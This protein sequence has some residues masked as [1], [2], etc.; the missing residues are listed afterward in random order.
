MRPQLPIW[1]LGAL[2]FVLASIR[3]A[4]HQSGA[5]DLACFDQPL[6]LLSQGLPPVSSVMGLHLLGDHA[7]WILW[8]LALLYRAWADPH[9][10]LLLQALT[11][12]L[13]AWTAQLLGRQAGCTDRQATTLALAY[14]A[15]PLVFNANLFDF[16]PD[17]FV[18]VLLMGALYAARAAK[19]GWCL[20]LCLAVAGCKE[21]MGLTVAGLGAYLVIFERRPWGAAV[22][23]LGLGSFAVDVAW[24]IP[25][26]SGRA[27]GAI[28]RYAYLGGSV[29]EIARNLVL[30][31]WRW[32]PGLVSPERLVY[33]GYLFGPLAWGLRGRQLAPLV[34]ALP[35]L[36]LNLLADYP[37]QHDVVHHYALPILPFL[38][39]AAADCLAHQRTWVHSDRAIRIW[40][41]VA[42]LALAKPGYFAGPY[43]QHLDTLAAA[44]EAIGRVPPGAALL[45]T[46]ELAPHLAHRVHLAFTDEGAPPA[47]L[48]AYDAV[49]LDL[50]HPGWRSSPA[51]AAAL[52]DRLAR[53]AR[54]REAYTSGPI[55]LFLSSRPGPLACVEAMFP[56]DIALPPP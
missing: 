4:L 50:R 43:L 8:P 12:A 7:A 53:D 45:T 19:P 23:A 25:H 10:L 14:A 3:H 36:A 39:A 34:A 18:P 31:P 32:L 6:Y 24:V 52:A 49:L 54:F 28:G 16:H 35:A 42:F 5:F 30:A 2:F 51:F 20:V 17:A 41:A 37:A 47:D 48:A 27:P 22:L 11:L 15:H 40:A 38:V 55:R 56:H 46:H 44:N 26:F 13:G 29:P 9:L 1:A 33:L 21:V